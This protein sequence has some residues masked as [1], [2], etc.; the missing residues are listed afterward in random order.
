MS[1]N[2]FTG[3]KRIKENVFNINSLYID[4]DIYNSL[5]FQELIERLENYDKDY[6]YSKVGRNKYH[7]FIKDLIISKCKYNNIA[8]PNRIIYSG[9]GYY[10]YWDLLA[11]SQHDKFGNELVGVPKHLKNLYERI[12]QNLVLLFKDLGAD[13]SCT[14][15]T[16]VL[17]EEGTINPKTNESVITI[18][19]KNKKFKIEEFTHLLPYSKEEARDYIKKQKEYIFKNDILIVKKRSY[20]QSYEE[21]LL[22]YLEDLVHDKQISKGNTNN[23]FYLYYYA[24]K[25]NFIDDFKAKQLFSNLSYKIDESELINAKK[26]A[27]KI[28]RK[29]SK[30]KIRLLLNLDDQDKRISYRRAS[31]EKVKKAKERFKKYK[32]IFSLYSLRKVATIL[33]VSKD[34]VAKLKKEIELNEEEID[35]II[36]R[37]DDKY[38][39]KS[40]YKILNY[41]YDN[42]T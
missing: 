36:D 3:K 1:V 42:S 32:Y 11:Q 14:D 18:L 26:Q 38:I 7:R 33:E 22:K 39:K 20:K 4:L 28:K 17:K 40:D 9:R 10:L 6:F 34:T 21:W 37:N 30:V 2:T 27:N 12:L 23:F 31:K 35:N 19:N 5:I 29:P 8:T 41:I 16:R 24:L 25:V 15:V 13:L